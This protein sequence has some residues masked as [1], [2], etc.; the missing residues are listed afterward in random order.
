MKKI[1]FI[2]VNFNNLNYTKLFCESLQ[3]QAGL[4]VD[5]NVHCSVVDNSTIDGSALEM[6]EYAKNYSWISYIRAD[7]NLGYFGGLNLGLRLIEN[8]EADYIGI[9]NN[10]I[11]LDP[12]FCEKLAKN[13]Y[14]DDV[15]VICPD[16]MTEDGIHQNPHNLIQIDKIRRFQFD[17][18]FCH[19]YM[20]RS[21]S[22]ILKLFKPV[23]SSTPRP[24]SGC[25]I[26]MGVG[27][28]YLLTTAFFRKF[29][30]LIYPHFLYAEE[31][32][33]TNQIHSEGGILWFDPELHLRHAESAS[34]SKIPKR[35]AYEFGR[36]SYWGCR[37]FLLNKKSIQ[38]R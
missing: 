18:Y 8:R 15:Y 22:L 37:K 5:F 11:Y 29:E 21:I 32:Y 7:K 25:E 27:A 19:Y 2:C 17:L 20:A 16:V 12:D 34:L 1:I 28:C 3:L 26:H 38:D 10:D 13:N 24:S 23:K 36:V 30:K 6:E 31:A 35:T 33:L 4:G 9:C 14:A